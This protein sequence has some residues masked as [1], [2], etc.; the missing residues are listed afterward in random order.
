MA[1]DRICNGCAYN[2]NG[3]CTMRKTNQG[4]K[5]LTT[6]E[7]KPDNKIEDVDS[8]VLKLEEYLGQKKFELTVD[9]NAFNRGVVK[10]LEYALLIMRSSKS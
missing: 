9:N 8:K 10:G 7:Y 2:N 5:D 6:C 4:L 1:K 3:W